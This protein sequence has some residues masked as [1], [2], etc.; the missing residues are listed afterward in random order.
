MDQNSSNGAGKR[1]W[2]EKLG[3]GAKDIPKIADDFKAPKSEPRPQPRPAGPGRAPQPVA[4]PA[5]MAPRPSAAAGTAV[6][7]APRLAVPPQA[8]GPESL[9][10]RLK[11][12]RQATER[13]AEQR[14]ASAR[15]KP[16]PPKRPPTE[17]EP[18]RRP[19]GDKPKFTFADEEIAAARREAPVPSPPPAKPAPAKPPSQ[20]STSPSTVAR[21]FAGAFQP[22]APP[23]PPPPIVPPRP[24]LGGE[25]AVPLSPVEARP[26]PPQ[27]TFQPPFTPPQTAGYRPL[28][29][30][31]FQPRVAVPQRRGYGQQQP[32]A[33]AAPPPQREPASEP[34]PG[35]YEGYRRPSARE[36]PQPRD[37]NER[38]EYRDEPRL[39]RAVRAAPP[40]A[41]PAAAYDDEL[42]DVFDEPAPPRRRAGPKDYSR[43][44]RE[45]EESYGEEGRRRSGPLLLL[46][47]LLAAA[48]AGGGVWYYLTQMKPVASQGATSNVPVIPAPEQPAKVQ[49]EA[50]TTSNAAPETGAPAAETRKKQI[51]DRILGEQ[52]IEGDKIVPTEE[53]PQ[54]PPLTDDA[55]QSSD[56]AGSVEPVPGEAGVAAPPA[57]GSAQPDAAEPVPLPLPLPPPGNDT[58]GSVTPTDGQRSADTTAQ[59][60]V[61]TT[62][63][64]PETALAAGTT[65]APAAA[66]AEAPPA[67]PEPPGT[68]AP[69]ASDSEGAAIKTQ[70]SPPSTDQPAE[71]VELSKSRKKTKSADAAKKQRKKPRI[72]ATDASQGA[73]PLVLVPPSS[74]VPAVIETVAEQPAQQPRAERRSRSFFSL[75]SG[76][77]SFKA[78]GKNGEAGVPSSARTN[79]NSGGGAAG[80][81]TPEQIEP[82]ADQIAALPQPPASEPELPAPSGSKSYSV[83]LASFR[84]EA[85]ALAEMDRLRAAHPDVLGSLSSRITQGTVSGTTRYRLRAGGLG[86]RRAAQQVCNSLISAGERD[87]NVLGP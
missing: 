73:E 69:S 60:A 85:E 64:A 84:S 83:Q 54:Q 35:G 82:P 67:L 2:R 59:P 4:R 19:A 36:S 24:A 81:G 30:P 1:N 9:A 62:K 53:P 5:P 15:D 55:A 57:K 21:E 13:L 16:E 50:S 39:H 17:P 75:G 42:D 47:L 6:R 66:A 52:A 51:Y 43:A 65:I 70:A 22:K 31:S 7:A 25:R 49:P 27:A 61:T 78:R 37:E 10:D 79:F 56:P 32:A 87:C 86:S 14:V 40:R 29:P 72:E 12:Q 77:S 48:V 8:N 74:D 41:K 71:L 34:R 20:A 26:R 46:L 45:F 23:A 68:A 33:A 76:G 28:D 80:A 3:I 44:H 63:S 38:D 18:G 11:A 58:Q